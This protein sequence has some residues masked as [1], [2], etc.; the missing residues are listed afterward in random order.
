MER[1][2]VPYQD[3]YIDTSFGKTHLIET[4]N[5]NG[6]PLL[7]FHGG[8]ATTA[9]NLLACDFLLNDFHIYAVDTIGHPGKSAEVS[10]SPRNYDYGKWGSEIISALNYKKL[11]CFAGS[12]GASILA[13]TMCVA[14]EKIKKSVLYVPSGIKNAPQ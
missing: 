14:P 3:L 2:S 10:L 4:G 1:L 7:V 12:F 13:K 11:S 8:N 9:Y 5:L 6:E